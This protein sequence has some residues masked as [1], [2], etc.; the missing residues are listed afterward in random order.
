MSVRR[1]LIV[2]LGLSTATVAATLASTGPA[3]AE[4][5]SGPS[6]PSTNSRVLTA[7]GQQWNRAPGDYS[8]LTEAI[9]RSGGD[10][11]RFSFPEAGLT[12]LSGAE[13]D[14][15]T[16]QARRTGSAK[17]GS[18]GKVTAIPATAFTVSSS[19]YHVQAQDGEWWNFNGNWDFQN[20][21]LN[22]KAPD[23]AAGMATANMPS[24]CFRLDTDTFFAAMVRGEDRSSRGYRKAVDFDSVVWGVQ[25]RNELKVMNVDH[26]TVTMSYRR[27]TSGCSLEQARGKFYF[28]H[29][30]DGNASWTA[31]INIGALSLSYTGS[32]GSKLQKSSALD[33]L[34]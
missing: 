3:T 1:S 29:N 14:R 4:Q 8:A 10:Q 25:D 11:V 6:E 12:D 20:K 5:P 7:A 22:G 31:A 26:G 13:A 30:T 27:R 24:A 16:A 2:A 18:P 9:V 21:Y 19:W 33:Y 28:E 17:V 23:D 15:L 32:V 34:S